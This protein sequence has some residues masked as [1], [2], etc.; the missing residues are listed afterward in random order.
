MA[1]VHFMFLD[2]WIHN[3]IPLSRSSLRSTVSSG[4]SVFLII[5]SS[6][7]YITRE[8][9]YVSSFTIQR[10]D[11]LDYSLHT[12]HATPR[13]ARPAQTSRAK[14]WPP[15]VAATA[16]VTAAAATFAAPFIAAAVTVVA[17]TP[18]EGSRRGE[19]DDEADQERAAHRRLELE[20]LQPEVPSRLDRRLVERLRSVRLLTVSVRGRTG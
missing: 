4:R 19:D 8:I 11:S 16:A 17:P 3:R 7:R 10:R 15:P 14:E 13:T 18:V 2:V 20:V 12:H 5:Y 6:P 9:S 1:F